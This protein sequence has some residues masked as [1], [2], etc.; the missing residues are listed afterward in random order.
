MPARKKKASSMTSLWPLFGS[1]Q[2][3][4]APPAAIT[5][6]PARILITSGTTNGNDLLRNPLSGLHK[7]NGFTR[8]PLPGSHLDE[9]DRDYWNVVET[10]TG[11]VPAGQTFVQSDYTWTAITNQIA[12]LPAG[13]KFAWRFQAEGGSSDTTQRLPTRYRNTTYSVQNA[14]GVWEP[15]YTKTV[16]LDRMIAAT[17]AY[18][19]Q[20]GAAGKQSFFDV[21]WAG[22]Y[23]E[24]TGSPPLS[25][26]Q[27][28]FEGV[29]A[30]WAAYPD[31]YI[32]CMALN[33][34]FWDWVR[35]T[36]PDMTNLGMRVDS[37]GNQAASDQS[38]GKHSA[39][40]RTWIDSRMES[41]NPLLMLGEFW[42]QHSNAAQTAD[43]SISASQRQ[44]RA[45]NGF[46]YAYAQMTGGFQFGNTINGSAAAY[47]LIPM[48]TV[49]N[50]NI[51]PKTSSTWPGSAGL[52]FTT[53]DQVYAYD[54]VKRM[55]HLI[56]LEK[57]VF[58]SPVA[59]G[60]CTVTLTWHND[61]ATPPYDPY[62]ITLELWN[63]ANTTLQW[64][65]D[66]TETIRAIRPDRYTGTASTVISKTFVLTG[67][68]A[69]AHIVR[70][71]LSDTR[72]PYARP[73]YQ[74]YT[75]T[76]QADGSYVIGT[77]TVV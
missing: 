51:N 31:V 25:A 35:V 27:Y 13:A 24:W 1:A 7:W 77:V 47:R 29:K 22:N 52:E 20:F 36:Y 60:S 12:A 41:T 42:N 15:D 14:N 17:K 21:G 19:A 28:L 23:G 74:M 3:P 18:V 4:A 70:L 48:A 58:T 2:A 6:T 32:M 43:S 57:A 50:G 38:Y 61:G 26:L 71:R 5:L 75:Q 45:E 16:M 39:A 69:G 68:V 34:S 65:G 62:V 10:G 53:Q 40:T 76:R 72:T 44:D 59:G 73:L 37:F 56:W 11:A 67:V 64:S 54:A 9:Y 63:S 55:G 66:F 46:D 49:G 8:V 33:V 30:A